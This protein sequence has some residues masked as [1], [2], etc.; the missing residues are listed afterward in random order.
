MQWTNWITLLCAWAAGCFGVLALVGAMASF[1]H[2]ASAKAAADQASSMARGK[3]SAAS[4][5]ASMEE[6][7]S[8]LTTS[9]EGLLN[10]EKMRRVRQGARLSSEPDPVTQPAEWKAYMRRSAAI[11]QATRGKE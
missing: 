9:V 1:R 2:S 6:R 3:S 11:N 10:R 7:L 5:L 8:D 4:Q